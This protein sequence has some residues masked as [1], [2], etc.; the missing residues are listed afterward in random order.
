MPQGLTTKLGELQSIASLWNL[1]EHITWSASAA[2]VLGSIVCYSET[3]QSELPSELLCWMLVPV[4]FAIAKRRRNVDSSVEALLPLVKSISEKSSE[5]QAPSSISL[6]II[7]ACIVVCSI[8]RAERG[9]IILFV[10]G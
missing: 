9:I 4:V 8:F 2:L 10:S 7:A 5:T 3:K 6:W 1:M